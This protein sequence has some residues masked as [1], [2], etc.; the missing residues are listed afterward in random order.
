[1]DPGFALVF[2]LGGLAAMWTLTRVLR[3]ASAPP[4][5]SVP[6]DAASA[7]ASGPAALSDS[8][9]PFPAPPDPSDPE[10][11]P[12]D[13][14]AEA[15]EIAADLDDVYRRAA[16][17]REILGEPRFERAVGL[18][19][20]PGVAVDRL[21]A[22]YNGDLMLP[23]CAALEAIARRDGDADVRE[24]VLAGLNDYA[25]WTRF[26]TLRALDGRTPP[27]AT[28]VGRVLC[29]LD[30]SWNDAQLLQYLRE[31]VV[32]RLDRGEAP[33]L[34]D[35]PPVALEALA[36]PDGNAD[37]VQHLVDR[38][39]EP[40]LAPLRD[41]LRAGVDAH[42]HDRVLR[43]LGRLSGPGAL[44]VP[45]RDQVLEHPAL[46]AAAARV[47]ASLEQTPSR[48]V[49]LVGEPGSGKT[50]LARHVAR[51]MGQD[52]WRVFE[53]GHRELLAGMSYYGQLEER[54]QRLTRA[55]AAGR[56]IVW[57]VPDFHQMVQ[58]GR[59]QHVTWSLFDLLAPALPSGSL[60][61]LGETT[62]KGYE[63]A[64]KSAPQ[65]RTS[66]EALRLAPLPDDATLELARR[67][68]RAAGRDG[69]PAIDDDLLREALQLVQQ[70]LGDR[71]NPGA[72]LDFLKEARRG[73][74]HGST[75]DAGDA[76]S[77]GDAGAAASPLTLDDLL[78]TVSRL[79]GL[80]G[81]I[82]DERQTL[83]L[84]DVRRFFEDRIKGQGPA[85]SCL[86]ERIAMVK[87]G[88]TDPDRPLGVFLFA[89][90]TGTG[91]TQLT[92]ALAEFLFGSP[93]RMIRI[94]M[95]E[96]QSPDALARLLGGGGTDVAL[97]DAI[98]R[99]PF[100]VVLLDEFEKAHPAVWDV[101]L[102]LFDDGRLTD[103][104]GNTADFR[105]AIVILTSNLGGSIPAGVALGFTDESGQF[106]KAA[107]HRAIERTFRKEFLNR[108]DRVVVF[109]PLTRET[110]R[111]IL[112]TELRAAFNRRGL[113]RRAWSVEWDESA[114]EF[115]LERGFTRD[116]G[117]RPLR[118]A[119]EEHLLAPL[120]EA[121][122]AR[123]TPQGN[124]FLFLR[125]DGRRLAVEFVDPDA[126]ATAPS[127]AAPAVVVPDALRLEA[128]A[129]DPAG[130]AAELALVRR[131][132]AALAGVVLAGEWSARKRGALEAMN[133]PGFWDSPQ[134]FA[135]LGLAEYCDR[136]E[137][138]LDSA[139]GVLER[140]DRAAPGVQAR[141]PGD[142]LRHL[143]GK[144]LL[145]EGACADVAEGRPGDAFV[146]VRSGEGG[147]YAG[148]GA[149]PFA[150]RVGAM[151]RGWA[152][153]RGMK[154][155]VIEEPR[156][157]GEYRLLLAV[158][159][160]AAHRLLAPEDGLH[161]LEIPAEEGAGPRRVHVRVR[162][163]AQPAEPARGRDGLRDSAR[164]VLAEPGQPARVVRRYRGEPAPLVRDA[165]RG[166]RT[167]RIDRVLA[168][169]FDLFTP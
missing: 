9:P 15:C 6:A 40:R 48:P 2:F 53:A 141:V 73:H 149:R 29:A 81:S 151:Y 66:M 17:P 34:A 19:C 47:R 93:S 24:A 127:A 61:L 56:R 146:L 147:E 3:R 85:V 82:V 11:P 65:I 167:G 79:S 122:V 101:F 13:P 164:R 89:G 54:V 96:L 70:Y 108:L 22:L 125:G 123:R 80:P 86:V 28:I 163:E 12:R 152:E 23:A 114:L 50:A 116:L 159:G 129:L 102:Q 7:A 143:A 16:L 94:D 119:I 90:P 32:R 5:G 37:L 138:A 110:M 26:F 68:G 112:R 124:Q 30:G 97:V 43:E 148:D 165:V 59:S 168:G 120:A 57:L 87:A 133:E 33:T 14:V 69:G 45:A 75:G 157:A 8:V 134:R 55:L 161:V 88:I 41:E 121:I 156:A 118:R 42:G 135:V 67:W 130:T 104:Q 83:E 137:A 52:G 77:A 44:P 71:A 142:M 105:H 4:S 25:K 139:G 27:G 150:E 99:Q 153:R 72:L 60:V 35:V 46:T 58:A 154:L 74:G 107:V 166:W 39:N 128:V 18:L 140:L 20:D 155:A 103:Y 144:L 111:E 100:S 92:K 126:P 63:L 62:P 91:K 10:T 109:N 162:V 106:S 169:D 78:R 145:I 158:S 84:D 1:M 160:L 113:R 49:L 51:A 132:H 76:G 95:S 136:I 98:K 117:A 64:V 21:I 115:V 38:L 31:F 36:R 131:H